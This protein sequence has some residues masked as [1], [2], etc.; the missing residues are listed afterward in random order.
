MIAEPPRRVVLA[1][2]WTPFASHERTAAPAEWMIERVPSDSELATRIDG[3]RE[4]AGAGWDITALVAPDSRSV[5]ALGC[6]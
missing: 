1:T 4:L 2:T 5:V 3:W 6:R